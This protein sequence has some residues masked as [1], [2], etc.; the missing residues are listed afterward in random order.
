M[1]QTEGGIIDKAEKQEKTEQCSWKSFDLSGESPASREE[2]E[3]EAERIIT[4]S[5][6]NSCV[7]IRSELN[8]K[9][10]KGTEA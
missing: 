6:R 7:D 5:W 9:R 10:W 1:I 2:Q 3:T 4:R 8:L